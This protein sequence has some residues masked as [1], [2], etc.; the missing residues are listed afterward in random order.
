MTSFYTRATCSG[1]SGAGGS[2][3][4][5][6]ASTVGPWDPKLEHGSPVAA[7]LATRI[8]KELVTRAGMRIA[9]FSMDFLSPVPVATLDVSVSIARPGKKIELWSATAAVDS[10]VCARASAWVLQTTTTARADRNP[11]VRLDDPVPPMPAT[12]ASTYFEAVPR[13]GYGDALE[14]R[15]A[16][17]AFT[18]LGPATI[19][20]RL[21]VGIVEGEPVSPLARALAMV[22]SANGIS[23]ELD[24]RTHLF[25]PVN[26]TVSM[27]REPE[28]EWVGMRA[29]TSLSSDGVGT[30]RA[31]LFDARGTIGRALQTLF[32]EKR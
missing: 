32:V 26:L 2:R 20:S 17:G 28:G 9:Q 14:W 25:V 5:A 4:V 13:F 29:V 3:Y 8:E 27:T 1:A 24:V 16:E 30:S 12:A 22:D 15:F 23:A 7:L 18:E 6:S 19:W 31:R 11:E 21:K 10:R